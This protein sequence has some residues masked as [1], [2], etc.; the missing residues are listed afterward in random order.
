MKN[1]SFGL[2]HSEQHLTA[3]SDGHTTKYDPDTT[4]EQGPV[5]VSNETKK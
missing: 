3:A 2:L 1:Q 5:C 4:T